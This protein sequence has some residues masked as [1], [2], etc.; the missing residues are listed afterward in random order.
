ML[1]Q[2]VILNELNFYASNP[3]FHLHQIRHNIRSVLTDFIRFLNCFVF[4][5][6][7]LDDPSEDHLYMGKSGQI[8]IL[9]ADATHLHMHNLFYFS[10]LNVCEIREGNAKHPNS[11]SGVFSQ[12]SSLSNEGE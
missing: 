12:F 10:V 7:V 11:V 4:F 9:L 3:C 1:M 2:S 5:V 6:Q 8:L